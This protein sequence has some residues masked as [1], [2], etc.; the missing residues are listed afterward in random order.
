MPDGNE[1]TTV[2]VVGGIDEVDAAQWDACA[3]A[4]N[5][6]LSHAFLKA[7]EESGSASAETGWQPRH[8]IIEDADGRIA[9]CAPAYLKSHSQGE[10]VFDW[11]WA[12]A[13]HR[14]G[15]H[16]YPKLQCAV[17]FTPVTGPRLLLRPGAPDRLRPSLG[18]AM[19]QLCEQDG[20]S[21]A[22]ITFPDERDW[23]SLVDQGFLARVGLQF[24]WENR[25]YGSFDDFLADLSSRKRKAIRKERAQVAETDLRFEI[26]TGSDLTEDHWD[27]FYAFYC[28]TTGRKW[29]EAYLTRTFF[30]LLGERLADR[31]ALVLA[32]RPDG[33]AVGGALN[34]IGT[35]RLYGRYW[36]CL[37]DYKFLHF[38]ACYYRAIDFAIERGLN[39]VEAGAQGH[40]KLQRGY[41]PRLTYSAHLIRHQGFRSA[42]ARFLEAERE[43]VENGLKALLA[44][45][46]FKQG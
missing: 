17:P 23:R 25:G 12:D 36:G 41:L 21:S 46:P 35:D 37:A 31:V 20:L 22:H 19:A 18:L 24:H 5:P 42:V 3:G 44:D 14:A 40:H 10:Y 8:L 15:G 9:A 43:E 2:K 28:D 39:W 13:F 1:T 29:G 30:S 38:E 6:F 26:A 34:L 32:R 27:T 45:S 16:Y 33:R 7:L 11:G 4:D